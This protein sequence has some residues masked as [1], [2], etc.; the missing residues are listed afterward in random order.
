LDQ[1][2]SDGQENAPG[3]QILSQVIQLYVIRPCV[4]GACAKKTVAERWYLLVKKT[5]K[6]LRGREVADARL[7]AASLSAKV[8]GDALGYKYPMPWT[9]K[10]AIANEVTLRGLCGNKNVLLSRIASVCDAQRH[11][12]ATVLSQR[13][14]VQLKCPFGCGFKAIICF[15]LHG[16]Y[17]F[18]R[19]REYGTSR[20]SF[21]EICV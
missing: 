7:K 13:D 18:A 10:E 15:R 1:T 4:V 12:Y 6:K 2:A 20:Y 3:N 8:Q 11:R 21:P 17:L 14:E 19:L 16:E 5:L 9:S